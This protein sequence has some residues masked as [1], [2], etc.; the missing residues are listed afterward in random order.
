MAYDPAT[1]LWTN[2]YPFENPMHPDYMVSTGDKLIS[3]GASTSGIGF[4]GDPLL[5]QV[6][7]IA[8]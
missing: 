8:E 7:D 1:N 4:A 3:I 2:W 5:V 6:A